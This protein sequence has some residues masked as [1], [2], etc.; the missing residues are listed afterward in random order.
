MAMSNENLVIEGRCTMWEN[1]GGF[2]APTVQI[3]RVLLDRELYQFV[4]GELPEGDR[5]GCVDHDKIELGTL[6]ITVERIDLDDLTQ[7]GTPGFT[8]NLGT[9]KLKSS[10]TP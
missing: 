4:H 10:G 8:T 2:S 6:R 5:G 1:E 3:G 9:L 7:L